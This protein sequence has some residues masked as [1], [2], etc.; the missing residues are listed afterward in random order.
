MITTFILGSYS[1]TFSLV[2]LKYFQRFIQDPTTKNSDQASWLVIIIASLL[3]PVSLPLSVLEKNTNKTKSSLYDSQ[4][5]IDL[6][7]FD[8]NHQT[9]S[10]I[11]LDKREQKKVEI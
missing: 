2:F 1:L 7:Y 3:W 10:E 11:L 5:Q 9:Y 8:R 4:S 6:I